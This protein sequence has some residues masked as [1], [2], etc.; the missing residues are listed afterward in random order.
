VCLYLCRYDRSLTVFSPD[1]HL[2]QAEYAMEAVARVCAAVRAGA[3]RRHAASRRKHSYLTAPCCPLALLRAGRRCCGRSWLWLC[4]F[5]CGAA[6]GGEAAGQLRGNAVCLACLCHGSP[7]HCF[8]RVTAWL[9]QPAGVWGCR[10]QESRT[11][12]KLVE[13]DEHLA[14]AF[15]GLN[16]DARVLVDMVLALIM[17]WHC[18][19]GAQLRWWS[20]VT[21]RV[22]AGACRVPVTPVDRRG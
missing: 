11:I 22:C 7:S 6:R 4:Y 10:V 17:T 19:R 13:L 15:S 5:G 21:G 12:R 20:R 14:L 3:A 9:R 16:A 8:N 18:L 2:L 1:G